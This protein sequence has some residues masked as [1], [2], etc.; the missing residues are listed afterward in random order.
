MEVELQ[1]AALRMSDVDTPTRFA[2]EVDAPLVEWAEKVLIS[3]PA[4]FTVAFNQCPTVA[5]LIGL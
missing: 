3:I 2:F 1:L 4:D 5:A